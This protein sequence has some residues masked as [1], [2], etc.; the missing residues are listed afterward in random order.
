V[1]GNAG[2]GD[3]ETPSVNAHERGGA[4]P[5]VGVVL[6]LA[7]GTA[8]V[9]PAGEAEKTAAARSEVLIPWAEDKAVRGLE[10]PPREGKRMYEPPPD[11]L[12]PEGWRN[13][14]ALPQKGEC[15]PDGLSRMRKLDRQLNKGERKPVRLPG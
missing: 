10:R 2:V 15:N 7:E 5:V 12:P 11:A 3:V 14:E 13:P 4:L 1:A 8:G 6:A 9:E